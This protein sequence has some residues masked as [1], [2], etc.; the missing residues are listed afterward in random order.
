MR[1][2]RARFRRPIR[3]VEYTVA[4]AQDI[5]GDNGVAGGLTWPW[6]RDAARDV[7][8]FFYL[9]GRGES[10]SVPTLFSFALPG[11]RVH[12]AHQHRHATLCSLPHKAHT[13]ANPVHTHCC[14][15]RQRKTVG[16]R[17]ATKKNV[18]RRTRTNSVPWGPGRQQRP[19]APPLRLHLLRRP[20]PGG[21][22]RPT[23]YRIRLP[24]LLRHPPARPQLAP[25]RLHP[26]GPG[27]PPAGRGGGGQPAV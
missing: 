3:V 1:A 8:I 10:E 7:H 22:A 25:G 20:C 4:C 27:V 5:R 6:G 23:P 21:H 15:R 24:G 13:P 16:K 26:A 19:T 17:A 9:R 11:E 2:L 18:S 12:C 14:A